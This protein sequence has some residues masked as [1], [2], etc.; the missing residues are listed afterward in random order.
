[1]LSSLAIEKESNALSRARYIGC[2]KYAENDESRWTDSL[3]E[4]CE[5]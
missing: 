2:S 4:E 3:Q 5:A 1:M